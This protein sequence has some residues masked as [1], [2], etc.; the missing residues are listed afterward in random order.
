MDRRKFLKKAGIIA[1]GLS[2]PFSLSESALNTQPQRIIQPNKFTKLVSPEYSNV[3]HNEIEWEKIS[4]GL[5]FSRTNV[6]QNGKLIDTIAGIKIN[7]ELNKINLHTNYNKNND[8]IYDIEDWQ[9]NTN[10][11]GVINSGQYLGMPNWA[12]PCALALSNGKQIGVKY[13]Q[14]SKGMLLSEPEGELESKLKKA[15]LLDFE[16]DSFNP[17]TTQYTEGVQHW[18]ILLD[19]NGKVKVKPTLWQANRTA[20]GKTNQEEIIFMTTEGGFFTLHN[21]G[22]FLRDSNKRDDNGFN[23]HT[24]MNLDGGYEACMAVNTP[25]IKYTTFGQF[26]TQGPNIDGTVLDARAILPTTIGVSKR[27]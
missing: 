8:L 3:S 27:F 10:S 5:D 20:V 11:L 24:A 25:E 1:G 21:L 6:Y 26:E 12:K 4:E 14:H 2:I 19:R 18:P 23:I 17:D 16:H 7:P 15:D 22:Q 9:E 13:N